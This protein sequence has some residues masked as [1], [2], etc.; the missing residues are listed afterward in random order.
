VFCVP[1]VSHHFY[2][3]VFSDR[4]RCFISKEKIDEEDSNPNRKCH[5][6]F[7]YGLG[8]DRQHQRILCKAG[9]TPAPLPGISGPKKH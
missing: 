3:S 8:K 9:E 2:I 1:V 6:A 7:Q 5:R 4:Y